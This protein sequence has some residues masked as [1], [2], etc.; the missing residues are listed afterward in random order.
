MTGRAGKLA[1]Q[2]IYDISEFVEM[3][4]LNDCPCARRCVNTLLELHS[5]RYCMQ[6]CVTVS[7]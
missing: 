3:I 1:D 5:M 4:K 7:K 2:K 6:Y